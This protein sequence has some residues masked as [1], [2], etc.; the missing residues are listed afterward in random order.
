MPKKKAAKKSK[1]SKSGTNVARVSIDTS[2]GV[3]LLLGNMMEEK[4]RAYYV[5]TYLKLKAK[6]DT[7]ASHVRDFRKKAKEAGVNMQ[8]LTDTLSM[9][10]M[11][12]LEVADY[13]KQQ[14][15]FFRDRGM[16]V[17]IALFE[18][19]FRSSNRLKSRRSRWAGT[20]A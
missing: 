15:M 5:E 1:S 3:Q 8:A 9:E 4:D 14:M 12:P 10:R 16:P 17:Q 2:K 13:L 6:L 11:D 7:A 18:P 20:R 19:K